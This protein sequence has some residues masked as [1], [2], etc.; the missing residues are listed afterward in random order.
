MERSCPRIAYWG[1]SL[2]GIALRSVRRG[3]R[4]RPDGRV[5]SA[6]AERTRPSDASRSVQRERVG[7]RVAR[8]VEDDQGVGSLDAAKDA[9]PDEVDVRPLVVRQVLDHAIEFDTVDSPGIAELEGDQIVRLTGPDGERRAFF[10]GRHRLGAVYRERDFAC[11]GDVAG[12]VLRVVLHVVV[13][14]GKCDRR[15]M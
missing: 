6:V 5:L 9:R 3:N 10:D 15:K 12:E 8:D 11:L 13:A 2:H 4:S 1:W 14:V 7:L